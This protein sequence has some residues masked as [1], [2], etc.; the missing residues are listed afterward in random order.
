MMNGTF[1]QLRAAVVAGAKAVGDALGLPYEF[2]PRQIPS[3]A[4]V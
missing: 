1:E 2:M 4:K 3:D